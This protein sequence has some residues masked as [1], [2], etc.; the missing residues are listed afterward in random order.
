MFKKLSNW[1]NRDRI[2]MQEAIARIEERFT[3][4]Q[5][6]REAERA[7]RVEAEQQ[8]ISELK[9]RQEAEEKLKAAE[10]TVSVYRKQEEAD[11]A[12]RNGT[13]PWVEIKSDRLDPVK[14]IHI[15][16]DWNDAFV[17]YLKDNGIK[18]RDDETVVQKYLAFLYEDLINRLEQ[19][20]IDNSDKPR[21][22]D[23]E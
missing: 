16:L 8:F 20:V 21:V 12:R 6:A 11:E 19:K 3:E 7:A 15:E 9:A 22:N 1:W 10:D 2:A 4:E 5:I 23:F 17:Q 18:G 13:E 14:G